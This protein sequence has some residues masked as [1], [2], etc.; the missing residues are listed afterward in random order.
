VENKNEQGMDWKGA[1][2]VVGNGVVDFLANEIARGSHELATATLKGHDGYV[3]YGRD[4]KDGHGVH[5]DLKAPETP[6]KENENERGGRS[7]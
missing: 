5:G 6:T 7:M 4:G 2:K 1:A 3:Q